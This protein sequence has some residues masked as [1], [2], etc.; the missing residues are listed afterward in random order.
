M[1]IAG[2]IAC[3]G[4]CGAISMERESRSLEVLLTTPLA[5][6]DIIW[7][8]F[9]GAIKRQWMVPSFIF[10]HLLILGCIFGKTHLLAM[11]MLPLVLLPPICAVTASGIWLSARIRKTSNASS[12]NFFLW[13]AMWA[14]LPMGLAA[15]EEFI[16]GSNDGAFPSLAGLINPLGHTIITLSGADMNS[17]RNLEFELYSLG[18]VAAGTYQF[19]LLLYSGFY[20]LATVGFLRLASKR[21]AKDSIRSR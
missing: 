3:V 6:K 1:V 4:S 11:T 2:C 14:A 20:A 5:A 7:G 16:L 13:M 9:T 8:K 21:L 18:H 17:N 19:I 12:C 15:F 10:A